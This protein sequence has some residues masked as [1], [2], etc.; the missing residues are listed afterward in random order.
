[1]KRIGLIFF[2]MSILCS[3]STKKNVENIGAASTNQKI[4]S[5]NSKIA[6]TE[7]SYRL[8]GM[9]YEPIEDFTI[10]L[11]GDSCKLTYFSLE[12]HGEKTV[13]CDPTLLEAIGK[14]VEK[15]KMYNYE[16]DYQ[17]KFEILDGESWSLSINYL[18]RASTYS[19]GNN[20]GPNDRGLDEVV[21]IV[22]EYFKNKDLR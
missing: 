6:I 18:N 12:Q 17:P 3:C 4:E 20:A 15:Y 2:V 10:K 14:V 9:M 7:Y 21:N 11:D 13:S 19:H 16:S 5:Q 1:M 22:H 8:R